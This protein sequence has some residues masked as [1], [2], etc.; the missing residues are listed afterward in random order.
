M[1]NHTKKIDQEQMKHFNRQLVFYEIHLRGSVS[2]SQLAQLTGL[3]LMSVSRIVDDLIQIGLVAESDDPF[4]EMLDREASHSVGRRPK[5]LHVV[6]D[7]MLSLGVEIDRDH[8]QAGVMDVNGE[9]FARVERRE[10]LSNCPPELLVQWCAQLIDELHALTEKKLEKSLPPFQSLGVVCPG[11]VDS[12]R[13]LIHFSTQLQWKEVN[14]V[15]LLREA[16]G[17]QQ[18]RLDNEVKSRGQAEAILGAGRSMKRVA[19]LNIGSG[20]GSCLVIRRKVYR[21]K[22]NMAGEIGHICIDPNGRLCE[23]GQRGCLQTC[24]SDL[25]LLQEAQWV[26]GSCTLDELFLAYEQQEGWAVQIVNHAVNYAVMALGILRNLY[27]PNI[28]VL[29]GSLV[30]MY[31]SFQQ[32]IIREYQKQN[33]RYGIYMDLAISGFGRDGNLVGAGTLAFGLNLEQNL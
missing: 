19:L 33:N 22:G 9:I 2:R 1:S 8:I 24:L 5:L 23:C 30:E 13:G 6:A 7:R 14:L 31:P 17:I 32:A 3:T 10:N 26:R 28:V 16:T 11:I 21:G 4:Q 15:D 18:I 20:V 12:K 25:A 29:C 27:A